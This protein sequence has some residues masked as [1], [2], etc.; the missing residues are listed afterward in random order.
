M[1]DS[2]QQK[3]EFRCPQCGKRLKA[4]S[5][6]TG[7]SLACPGCGAQVIVPTT[8][9]DW[10]LG[11]VP[12]GIEGNLAE[13]ETD[14][15]PIDAMASDSSSAEPLLAELLS[16][17]SRTED[18]AIS[19]GQPTPAA[20]RRSVFD[21]DDL[22]LEQLPIDDL[23]HR[24]QTSKE[25]RDDKDAQRRQRTAAQQQR[26]NYDVPAR[27]PWLSAH[28]PSVTPQNNSQHGKDFE[29]AVE[30][31]WQSLDVPEI[32]DLSGLLP[33]MGNYRTS[34]T[35]AADSSPVELIEDTYR[36]ACPVCG[37]LQYVAVGRQGG[38]T[39]CPDCTSIFTIAAPPANW[40]PSKILARHNQLDMASP[41]ADDAPIRE[42]DRARQQHT[43]SILEK[44]EQELASESDPT[45]FSDN[46][47]DTR[48]FV[49]R[50]FG[51]LADPVAV[52]YML[53]YALTFAFAYGLIQY[54]INSNDGGQGMGKTLFGIVV[55][56]MI[57]GVVGMPMTSAAIALLEAVANR[58]HRVTQ[59]PS[60]NVLENF[61]DVLSV[62][63]A[64]LAAA[65]PG[66]L[67]GMWLGGDLPGSGR[68]QISGAMFSCWL[69]FP[70]FLLS[71][72]DNGGLMQLISTDVLR[73]IGKA[74]EAWAGFYLKIMIAFSGVMVLWFLL[75]GEGKSPIAAAV[76]GFLLPI[77]YFF[78]FQQ[79]GALA[80]AIGESLSFTVTITDKSAD[81]EVASDMDDAERG[82]QTSA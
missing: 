56:A 80:D 49:Q 22:V 1:S 30:E 44:A 20:P 74:A 19:Q 47:F 37:T 66:Y 26:K 59:W 16:D 45:Q 65:L 41:L 35:S 18:A 14:L 67:I 27:D 64:L 62:G 7:R 8:T 9:D 40:K 68:I 28:K 51:Y 24:Q 17:D 15:H 73:S 38:Q 77:L 48:A 78:T 36:I 81:S 5:K 34:S 71:T 46:D 72:L 61:G 60:L 25:I 70:V 39:K 10:P 54:G 76:G 69:L 55:G 4:K 6:A 43:L 12:A 32:G 50:T 42:A 33:A 79:L 11:Q 52:G 63:S 57:C 21:D 29:A 2:S 23:K 3:I 31:S 75:L 58:Q 82:T 53:A 13:V